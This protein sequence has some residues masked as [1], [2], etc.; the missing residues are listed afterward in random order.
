MIYTH[1]QIWRAIDRFA[2]YHDT[3][4]SGLAK[5]AG[6]DATTFNPSK[7]IS[8]AGRPRWPSLETVAAI[9]MATDTSFSSFAN[10]V[11]AARAT[12]QGEAA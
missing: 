6:L 8:P 5:R 9:C 2:A 1:A 3:T 11:E 12:R 7:R 4:P 10:T